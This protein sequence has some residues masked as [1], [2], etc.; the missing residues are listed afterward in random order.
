MLAGHDLLEGKFIDDVE[1]DRLGGLWAKTSEGVFHQAKGASAFSSQ[2]L[3]PGD[4]VL[5]GLVVSPAGQ[6]WLWNMSG[7]TMCRLD[8]IKPFACWQAPGVADPK[9]DGDG[10]LWWADNT[11]VHRV[12]NADSLDPSDSQALAKRHEKRAVS[13][14]EI[15]HSPDGSVWLGNDD[16][17]IR[18]RRPVIERM[19]LPYGGLLAE[20]DDV[21]VL[22]FVRGMMRT[23]ATSA[24]PGQLLAAADGSQFLRSVVPPSELT[25]YEAVTQL[26]VPIAVLEQ[27]K[28]DLYG[29]IRVE[30][31]EDGSIYIARLT[32]PTLVRW[33]PS[34][35]EEIALPELERG[36]NIRRVQTDASG[37]VWVTLDRGQVVAYALESGKWI[38]YGGYKSISRPG[39]V[40]LGLGADGRFWLADENDALAIGEKEP[41]RYGVREGL[42]IGLPRRI[43]QSGGST[44]A[45]GTRGIAALVADRFVALTGLD[46][47]R[48]EGATDIFH[49]LNGDLYVNGADGV[50][51]IAAEDWKRVLA[52]TLPAVPFVRFDRWDGVRWPPM[53]APGPSIARSPDGTLWFSR[54]GGLMRLLP[55]AIV[56]K[57]S[58]PQVII[59]SLEIDEK[60]IDA[61][62]P[63]MLESGSHRLKMELLAAGGNRPE[64][65]RLRYRTIKDGAEEQWRLLGEERVLSLD[66]IDAGSYQ[67][68]TQASDEDGAWRGQVSNYSLAIRPMFYQTTWFYLLVATIVIGVIAAVYV[69]RM[70]TIRNRMHIQMIARIRERERIAR[71]LHDTILQ[72]AQGM[73]LSLQALASKLPSGDSFRTRMEAVLDRTEDVISEGR[74]RIHLLRAP[75]A[76]TTDLAECVKCHAEDCATEHGL[77]CNFVVSYAIRPLDPIVYEEVRQIAREAIANAC[78]HAQA[79]QLDVLI[80]YGKT[81]LLLVVK[82]N[83]VGISAD[84]LKADRHW[85]ISGMRERARIID[86]AL[87]IEV[88]ASGGTEVRLMVRAERAYTDRR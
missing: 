29:A 87:T 56:R 21:W 52:G 72:G 80:E 73:L 50:T 17:L 85:G 30:R 34:A 27:H 4:S 81:E 69:L 12:A 55:G 77:I 88:Q 39:L 14:E 64:K 25:D 45:L 62:I 78:V 40:G 31:A 53:H 20:G 58:M 2:P 42:S 19:P 33:S 36:A 79:R 9:F 35:S 24:S 7:Q 46:G 84:R 61:K 15:V 11:L 18:L 83:G 63:T 3:P 74:D 86:G 47:D 22:S 8:S 48:I 59:A 13:A 60:P 28:R 65:I 1:F 76:S 71:D 16:T 23:G 51:R 41:L 66:L 44:W 32:P 43:V 54:A 57:T 82:D 38:P 49:D 37:R 75:E 10:N 68:Q 5:G 6:P 26:D 70:R 67:I